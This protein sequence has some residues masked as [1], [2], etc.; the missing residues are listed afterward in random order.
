MGSR[1]RLAFRMRRQVLLLF[2]VSAGLGYSLVDVSPPR[3]ILT[4]A[5]DMTLFDVHV[6]GDG[7]AFAVPTYLCFGG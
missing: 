7:P 2:I 3:P 6:S 4:S 1:Y 5:A